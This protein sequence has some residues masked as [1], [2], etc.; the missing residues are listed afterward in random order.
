MKPELK[1]SVIIFQGEACQSLISEHG[2]IDGIID[3][4]NSPIC[5]YCDTPL[6]GCVCN[7]RKT[8]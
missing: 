2:F 5:A 7:G 4:L 8:A 6:V 3:I 1:S